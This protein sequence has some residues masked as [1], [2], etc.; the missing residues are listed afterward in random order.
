MQRIPQAAM[1]SPGIHTM[2]IQFYGAAS[3]RKSQSI[4]ATL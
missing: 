2:K 4:C 1:L 3:Q